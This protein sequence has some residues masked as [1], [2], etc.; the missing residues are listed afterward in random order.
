L[1]IANIFLIH[2]EWLIFFFLLFLA[3]TFEILHLKLYE[4]MLH[5]HSVAERKKKL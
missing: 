1:G 2:D 5:N 3:I 4:V